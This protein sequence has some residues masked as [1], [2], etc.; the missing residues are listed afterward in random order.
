MRYRWTSSHCPE[1]L[2]RG[3]Q[4]TTT[5]TVM[6]ELGATGIGMIAIAGN[7]PSAVLP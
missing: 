7:G 1:A 3:G 5:C 4:V 6:I 2:A